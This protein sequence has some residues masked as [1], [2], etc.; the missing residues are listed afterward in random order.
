MFL[1]AVT[2]H[3]ARVKLRNMN[4]SGVHLEC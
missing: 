2:E 3:G 4:T 1:A